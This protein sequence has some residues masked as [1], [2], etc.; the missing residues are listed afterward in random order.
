MRDDIHNK[1]PLS[2]AFRALIRRCAMPA[3]QQQTDGLAAY[4][5]KAVRNLIVGGCAQ[6]L[7]VRLAAETQAPSLFG[8]STISLPTTSALQADLISALR[9]GDFTVRE[10]VAFAANNQIEGLCL[11]AV[12]SLR[13]A[14]AT[15]REALQVDRTMRT[16]LA[17]VVAPVAAQLV[18]GAAVVAPKMMLT[19]SSLLPLGPAA[20]PL[21]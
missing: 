1:V 8:V 19:A 21:S 10:G 18:E 16:A 9:A 15:R 14:G 6:D 7:I 5:T 12:A 2:P 4:A 20:L 13:A 17:A 11:E 3:Y